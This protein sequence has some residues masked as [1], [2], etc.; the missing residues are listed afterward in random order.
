MCEN[1][2]DQVGL[3]V[4]CSFHCEFAGFLELVVGYAKLGLKIDPI[5]LNFIHLV[6]GFNC[7]LG[8]PR[9]VNNREG[10]VGSMDLVVQGSI[11]FSLLWEIFD[12]VE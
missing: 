1:I 5:L 8:F 2:V 12:L 10:V 11:Q 4:S 7:N 6:P 3:M 9:P